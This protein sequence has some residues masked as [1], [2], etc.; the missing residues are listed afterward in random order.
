MKKLF[1]LAGLV[2]LMLATGC[3]TS[4][5][6]TSEKTSPDGTITKSSVRILGTG[7]KASQVAAEGMFADSAN[8]DEGA[9]VRNAKASQQSTG[10]KEAFEG[11][12]T[13]IGPIADAIA[14][15]Q[16]VGGS[17]GVTAINNTSSNVPDASQAE[18]TSAK[19]DT[20]D[21]SSVISDIEYSAEKYTG[22]P[23]T[24]G[25]G[26][27]GKTGC[28]NCRAY[29][30]SHPET[31]MIDLASLDNRVIMWKALRR[32]GYEGN[33]VALPVVISP[34]GYTQKAK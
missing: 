22:T 21:T 20:T 5:T 17:K 23:L 11:F 24:D 7:D 32:L 1:M 26:V 31:Q 2:T 15:S 10:I 29:L 12:G 34:T 3:L 6:A 14:R 25:L 28:P 13:V 19:Q 9:G 33:D 18:L 8:G 16:G 30:A 4:A 27:Y